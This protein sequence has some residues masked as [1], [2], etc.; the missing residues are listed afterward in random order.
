MKSLTLSALFVSVLVL[1]C[2]VAYFVSQP[3]TTLGSVITGGEYNAT[4]LNT[5]GT[6]SVRTLFGSVGSVVITESASAGAQPIRIYDAK[7][8]TTAT[9]SL[10]AIIEIY[11]DATEGTYQF[12][13][14]VGNGVLV[15]VPTD[16]DGS[17]VLTTR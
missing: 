15:D 6:S 4:I 16:F 5:T 2:V 13:V 12:D 8:T 14:A 7:A 1:A 11:G 9:S 10:T 17:A 3:Q